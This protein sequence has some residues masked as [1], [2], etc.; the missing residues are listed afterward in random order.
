MSKNTKIIL[1]ILIGFFVAAALSLGGLFVYWQY[2]L[3]PTPKT[4]LTELQKVN[5]A[6]IE[7]VGIYPEP[8]GETGEV[9]TIELNSNIFEPLVTLDNNFKLKPV[10]AESW[11]N[12]DDLTWKI[13]LKKGIK[14]H[15]GDD[16]SAD[17]VKA[18]FEAAKKDEWVSASEISPINE[19]K[20]IDNYT[21][22]LKTAEPYPILL[23]KLSGV[24][25]LPKKIIESGDFK[26]NIG[27]GSYK[28]I[29][30]EQG[31]NMILERNDNYWGEKPKVQKIDYK[32]YTEDKQVTEWFSNGD[33]DL[34][35]ELKPTEETVNLKNKQG[36]KYAPVDDYYVYDMIFNLAPD[37]SPYVVGGGNPFK[38]KRVREA[39]YRGINVDEVIKESEYGL[40]KPQS[41]TIPKVTF[42]YN[43]NI[44]RLEYSP[45]KAKELLGE[46]GYPNGFTFKTDVPTYRQASAE[47]IAK[48]LAKVGVTTQ[49]NAMDD[50]S[51]G[52]ERMYKGD[53]TCF[54]LGIGSA[55]GDASDVTDTLIHS[56]GTDNFGKYSNPE[57]DALIEQTQKTL[58][59]GKRR[60]LFEQILEKYSNDMPV[61]PLWSSTFTYF[62][63]KD[64]D[65]K[66]DRTGVVKG[67]DV[68]GIKE[69][70][71]KPSFAQFTKGLIGL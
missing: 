25:V 24:F 56:N 69:I 43:P 21:L 53:F 63:K 15:N 71:E 5:I 58:D 48:Q 12:P 30:Y 35:D 62:A 40:A 46:A 4:D 55:S 22:E 8:F 31:K 34:T 38:D 2:F 52:L 51:T 64:I 36:I 3:K 57:I 44:K 45:E 59:Q 61:I 17:D 14:F 65:V 19:I 26:K 41:Q 11:T 50:P 27:T 7:P 37:N 47:A 32:F 1:G 16:F 18:S 29:S 39:I 49:V 33:V 68:A 54:I 42:G 66:W 20:I 6:S 67:Q 70:Q 9:T 23:N 28:F 60:K 10:L 13:Y